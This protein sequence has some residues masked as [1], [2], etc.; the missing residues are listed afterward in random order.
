MVKSAATSC[1]ELPKFLPVRDYVR[2]CFLYRRSVAEKVGD[3]NEQLFLV[4]D[5][6]YCLRAELFYRNLVPRSS[7]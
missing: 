2:A 6:E 1:Q 7:W 5:Y 4:E 3:Y